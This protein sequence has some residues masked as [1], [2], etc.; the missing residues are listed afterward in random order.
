MASI[1]KRGPAQ[2]EAR[3]RKKGWPVTCKTFDTKI[4]AEQWSRQIEG[5]MDCGVFISRTEAESTTLFDALERYI[6]EYII[7]RLAD[8]KREVNRA[9]AIQRRDLAQRF[10]ASIRGKDIAEFIKKRQAEGAGANAIRLDLTL[11]SKMFEVAAS[12]WGMESL[13]NPVKKANKPK[14]PSGRSRRLEG[15]EEE[16]LLAACQRPFRDVVKFALET[17]MRREEI[18]SI[19]WTQVD[20]Q[21]RFVHLPRT[22]N[23]EVRTVPLSPAALEVIQSMPRNLSGPVFGMAKDAI[24][25][26]MVL[27]CKKAEIE[28]MC[29]HDLRH[30]ATSRL[31]ENT[32]LDV[33]EIRLITGHKSMQ[34]LAR[35]SHIRVTHLVGKLSENRAS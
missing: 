8:S 5:E 9:K 25:K 11:L 29:F 15:D 21:K 30:E 32:D 6:D 26:A 33:M 17:A 22:K 19:E 2:W 18:A 27:A 28:G 12:D 13:S 24:T 14:L 7:P 3:I 35:Y 4:Q 31:F 10:L 23:G 20:L 34:M 16:R 1:R